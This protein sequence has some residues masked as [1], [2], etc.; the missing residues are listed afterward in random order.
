MAPGYEIDFDGL[1]RGRGGLDT[2]AVN[3]SLENVLTP[4]ARSL[5]ELH[6]VR[7]TDREWRWGADGSL[8]LA[9]NERWVVRLRGG[10][11]TESPQ[12]DAW[13]VGAT[14]EYAPRASVAWFA[15]LRHYDDTGEIENALLFTSAA[16]AVVTSQAGIGLRGTGERWSWRL[17]VAAVQANYAPTNPNLDFFRNLY[18]DRDWSVLQL[19]CARTF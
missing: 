4:R 18:R 7:T 11:T 2:L 1:R 9:L 13:Y 5:V 12:F 8:N 3:A 14:V 17:Y 19:S 16:P 6:A 15:T 10:A